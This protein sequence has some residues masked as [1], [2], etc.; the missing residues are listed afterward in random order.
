MMEQTNRFSRT[1][2]EGLSSADRLAD[3]LRYLDAVVYSYSLPLNRYE[4]L[5]G[6]LEGM[7][8][9]SATQALSHPIKVFKRLS[10]PDYD[11]I[12]QFLLSL[13]RGKNSSVEIKYL[14]FNNKELYLKIL[15]YPAFENGKV[16]RIDGI[17]Y[18]ITKEK[19]GQI[20]LQR[21]E[22]KLRTI[23]DTADDL[24]FILDFSGNFISV[25]SN[26]ALSIEYSPEELRGKHF[27]EFIDE[28]NRALVTRSF[29]DLLSGAKVVTFECDLISKYG[30]NIVFEINARPVT[31]DRRI[32]GVIGIGRNI[33]LRRIEQEKTKE[34]TNKYLEAN[35][36]ISIERDRAKQRISM[37][38]E[39]NQMKN[40][41]VSNISHEFRTPLASIIGF[42]E[43][44][45]SDENIP[46]PVRKEFNLIILNEA[47]RLS[48]LINDVLDFS[49]L[50]EGKLALNKTEFNISEV[51]RSMVPE[52]LKRADAKSIHFSF[53][54]PSEEVF[55]YAD[56]DR[57]MQ[58]F[59]HILSNAIKFSPAGGRITMFAQKIYR[60]FEVIIT[61]T[62]IG[63]PKNDLPFIFQKFYR[64]SRPGSEIPGTG[65]GLALV[66]QI[67]DLHK[68]LITAQ[69]EEEKGTT[70]VIKLP[71]IKKR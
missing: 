17:I 18:D 2:I 65:L 10:P 55:L 41:F 4:L 61:D 68:G 31:E 38:E 69:S 14:N 27:F 32:S 71:Q 58:C 47:K 30:K 46:S 35:R 36:L 54:I 12:K 62:G 9:L 57:I 8:G 63:I 50:E 37:L 59:E 28:Q 23:F 15:G 25:N 56:K 53:E 66:K 6:Q 39:L 7:L 52:I 33:T 40:E 64:V 44:L 3:T 42:S 1:I 45:D 26:G 16:V 48:K 11:Q 13:Y 19:E 34:L 20:L 51:L 22:Q 49:R 60:E 21:S 5:T 29:Q 70:F 24:I 43:T 67:I